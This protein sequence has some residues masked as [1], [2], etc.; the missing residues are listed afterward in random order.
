MTSGADAARLRVTVNL[1][2]GSGAARRLFGKPRSLARWVRAWAV[3]VAAWLTLDML[4][5]TQAITYYREKG[6]AIPW[7]LF[8]GQYF[9]SF[10]WAFFTPFILLLTS[11]WPITR[12]S[13]KRSVPIHV[14][15]GLAAGALWFPLVVETHALQTFYTGDTSFQMAVS[16]AT[17][18]RVLVQGLFYYA[19]AA[20]VAHGIHFYRKYR[21]RDV[22]A[23]RLAAQLAEAQLSILR[24]QLHPHFLFNTLNTIS[25][26]IHRDVKAADR[27]LAMLGHLLRDSFEKIGAQ[28][29]ALK[30]EM[31]F[32]ERYLEIEKTRFQDRLVIET[33]IAPETLDALIPNLI[34]QPLVEN[35]IRHGISRRSGPGRIE[36]SSWCD[37]GM[38][39]VRVRDDGPG[40]SETSSDIP[41]RHGVGLANTQARLQQLYGSRHHFDLENRSCGGLDV[42]LSI[43]FRAAT[44]A[45]A[46]TAVAS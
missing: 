10:V 12:Q 15:A 41:L 30:Q 1:V 19:Q 34:L 31:D 6:L 25:A 36:V 39:A 9:N 27:M 17:V 22:S 7:V 42:T 13:W 16:A 24:M 14:A 43:P 35:S 8:L 18:F 33:R 44:D 20:A 21:D 45:T 2:A 38:L 11:R 4:G 5:Q 26:L 23:S 40:L 32:L 37:S 3:S 46:G 29:V 28:E